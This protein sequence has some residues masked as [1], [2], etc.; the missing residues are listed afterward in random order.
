MKK[1]GC[2][3]L[4]VLAF[5]VEMKWEER[6]CT[7]DKRAQ[8][9]VVSEEF[10]KELESREKAEA[11]AKDIAV[12]NERLR[13]ENAALE[14]RLKDCK[15]VPETKIM[16]PRRK[17]PRASEARIFVPP[18]APKEQKETL[19][20]KLSKACGGPVK[21]DAVRGKWHCDKHVQAKPAPSIVIASEEKDFF[22][23]AVDEEVEVQAVPAPA[24]QHAV[25]V[26]PVYEP[27]SRTNCMTEPYTEGNGRFYPA[28]YQFDNRTNGKC[29]CGSE[30]CDLRWP[31][32]R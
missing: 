23:N 27:L 20:H 24:L 19:A 17:K 1:I 3:L 13:V 2:V 8:L 28:G 12:E 30:E 26:A 11:M 9:A 5:F 7:K 25:Y 4:V 15:P 10:Q 21:F 29:R 31:W 32:Q 22:A 16:V 6:S 18:P 14:T